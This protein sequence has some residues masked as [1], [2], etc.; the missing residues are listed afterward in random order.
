VARIHFLLPRLTGSQKKKPQ[1]PLNANIKIRYKSNEVPGI[2]NPLDGKSVKI[3][4][5][6]SLP[7]IT[8]GQA[9]VFYQG[10]LCLGG[11]IIQ[12]EKQ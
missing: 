10:D 1:R 6:S 3:N 9:A 11:G 8:P 2:I 7:D 12:T 4:L 5:S